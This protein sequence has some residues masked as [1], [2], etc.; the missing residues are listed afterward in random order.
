MEL[1]RRKVKLGSG[2]GRKISF[3]TINLN[4][5]NFAHPPGVY[6]CSLIINDKDYSGALYFGP[7]IHHKGN[8]LEIYILNF[9]SKIYGKF[10][11]FKVGKKIR[12]PK[13]FTD[14]QQLKKQIE[15]DIKSV[16]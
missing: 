9:S 16:V 4:V 12:S 8:V 11:K 7:K 3:P 15:I 13:R 6:A 10:I 5:C 1:F 2:V 14:I